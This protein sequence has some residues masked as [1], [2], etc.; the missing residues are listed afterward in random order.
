MK[1]LG[2]Y[3]LRI[4]LGFLAWVVLKRYQPIIIG[5]AGTTN[6][7]F[8]KQAIEQALIAR[9]ISTSSTAHNFNTDIGIPLTILDLPSGYNSYQ[10]WLAIIPQA[11][12]KAVTRSLPEV[13]VLE[14]GISHPGDAGHLS[15]IIQPDILVISDITQRY[16]E[17]F[18]DVNNLSKEYSKLIEKV[19]KKGLVILNYDTMIVR[20]LAKYCQVKVLFF[21]LEDFGNS[22]EDIYFIKN[23]LGTATGQK[24]EIF[25][26][27]KNQSLFIPKFG[28]HH[29]RSLLV[30][31]IV[32]DSIEK[33]IK[34]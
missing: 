11:L 27:E 2:F 1:R 22:R 7:T 14:L 29:L 31:E 15:G 33:Y 4:Y 12:V 18:G 26:S 20:D 21:S 28:K 3:L 10:Q 30:S 13:L 8:T 19:S 16:R 34:T 32:V 17:N 25:S 6:K 9:N 23:L 24:F 5:I